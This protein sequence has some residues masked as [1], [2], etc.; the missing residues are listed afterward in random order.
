MTNKQYN[1]S[2]DK[3]HYKDSKEFDNDMKLTVSIH[4][5]N[6]GQ[7]KLQLTREGKRKT[8]NEWMYLRL[9]RLSKQEVEGI[10]LMMT[11]ALDEM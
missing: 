11:K 5:Y 2:L 7:R 10:I 3:E 8:D 9:G 4:S 1:K 6:E